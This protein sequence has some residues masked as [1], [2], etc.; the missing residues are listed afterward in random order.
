MTRGKGGISES[1]IFV[2]KSAPVESAPVSACYHLLRAMAGT[3]TRRSFVTLAVVALL[4][5]SL[6]AQQLATSQ[7]AEAIFEHGQR[8]LSLGQYGDAERDFNRVLQLGT[9]SAPTY[10]N[11]GVVYLRTNRIDA[12]I[13]IL[14]HAEQLAPDT[15]GIRLN[16]GLAYFK[17]HE[18]KKAI[19]NF[20]F[21][22]SSD[23]RNV[24]AHYLMGVCDFMTDDFGAAV[25]AFEPILDS[26]Q[27]DLEL[28]YM[29][30]ISY[31]MM[32]R[33]DDA[34]SVF[35]R[36]VKAGGDTPHLHLL[37]G[38][39]YLALGQNNQAEV[40]LQQAASGNAVPFAHYYMGILYQKSGQIDQAAT[41]FEKEI[42]VDPS[43]S[44]AYKDLADIK[45]DRGAAA[46]AIPL[47]EKAAARNP[48]A[49][50]LFATLGRAYLQASHP[51]RS[52]SAF[53]RA[54]A[55]DDKNGSYH[56]Q[57]GRALLRAG[58]RVEASAEVARARV[59]VS[60][61]PERQTEV[62]TRDHRT[63]GAPAESH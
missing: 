38:K 61:V 47:L 26:Q 20:G 14:R 41:Q 11:L 30:G 33:P 49:P 55:L 39:A 3:I 45:L 59:L 52:I 19:P 56:L 13:K 23:P 7:N 63:P 58:H 36:L 44:W 18:F 2:A 57:L 22:V 32:K 62:L 27:D 8:A 15:P 51:E 4:L 28:L 40:E 31:G 34:R 24:Q 43:N 12:A 17:K 37:L 6:L 9:R 50:E 10:A 25:T 42:Q 5:S 21:V 29:L 16:L 48:D 1:F 46:D 53:R 35:E 54:V 60:N